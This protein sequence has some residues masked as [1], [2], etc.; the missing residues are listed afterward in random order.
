MEY[1]SYTYI[2]KNMISTNVSQSVN[3]I[4]RMY[5]YTYFENFPKVKKINS[6][7]LKHIPKKYFKNINFDNSKF[8]KKK[9]NFFFQKK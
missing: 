1:V 3:K 2:K 7:E 4:N 9:F 8:W 6:S 5:Y